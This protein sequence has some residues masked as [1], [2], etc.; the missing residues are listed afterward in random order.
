MPR[1]HPRELRTGAHVEMTTTITRLYDDYAAAERS[2][3]AV[4]IAKP[5]EL[6]RRWSA[7]SCY[8]AGSLLASTMRSIVWLQ[9]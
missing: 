3:C 8:S 4:N 1:L 5:P 2:E 7:A 6:L 9:A